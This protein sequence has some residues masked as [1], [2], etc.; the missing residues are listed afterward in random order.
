M[1][2]GHGLPTPARPSSYQASQD[3]L[4]WFQEEQLRQA[5]AQPYLNAM[6]MQQAPRRRLYIAGQVFDAVTGEVI[7]G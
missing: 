7:R 6:Q 5:A 1:G 4:R 2:M 3:A